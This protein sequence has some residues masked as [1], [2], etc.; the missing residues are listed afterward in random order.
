MLK[1][2]ID[3]TM[4]FLEQHTKIDN[5]NQLG[6]TMALYSGLALFHQLYGQ[7][8]EWSSYEMNNA[9]TS[10]FQF[11]W[12]YFQPVQPGKEFPAQT[13]SCRSSN[14]GDFFI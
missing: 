5:F 1:Y 12:R 4:S 9:G 3:W 14:L 7:V 13:P 6:A 2:L 10:L 11:S 8:T